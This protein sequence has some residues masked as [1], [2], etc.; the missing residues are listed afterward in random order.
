V[1]QI[2]FRTMDHQVKQ[3]VVKFSHFLKMTTINQ[4]VN[5]Q[6][7]FQLVVNKHQRFKEILGKWIR[8]AI[9]NIITEE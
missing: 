2:V 4:R 6:F 5:N 9:R 7:K 8:M 1:R 3:S